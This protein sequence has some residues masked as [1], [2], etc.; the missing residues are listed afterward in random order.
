LP[1]RFDFDNIVDFENVGDT[2]QVDLHG[3]RSYIFE[4]GVKGFIGESVSNTMSKERS[5]EDIVEGIGRLGLRK[6]WSKMK[7]HLPSEC[8]WE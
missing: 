8:T 1:K 5:E 3:E 4:D 6:I 2:F 7:R